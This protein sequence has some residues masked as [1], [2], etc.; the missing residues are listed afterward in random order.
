[1]GIDYL[2]AGGPE[3]HRTLLGAGVVIIEGLNLTGIAPGRYEMLCL[4][5]KILG[6]DGAPA[7]ALLRVLDAAE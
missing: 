1:V 5:L 7:R 3:T 6:G 2:S 4:P